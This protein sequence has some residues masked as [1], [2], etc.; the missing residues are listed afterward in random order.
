M[1]STAPITW[2]PEIGVPKKMRPIRSIHTG[3]LAPTSVTLMGVD[4]FR[5]RYNSAL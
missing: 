1:D 3:V 4:V 2:R 5:A